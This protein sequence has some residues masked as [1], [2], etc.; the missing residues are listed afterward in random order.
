MENPL[1]TVPAKENPTE[2]FPGIETPT[3]S[4]TPL[5]TLYGAPVESI[6]QNEEQIFSFEAEI[7]PEYSR[8]SRDLEFGYRNVAKEVKS[9][10]S[11][12]ELLE[13][14]LGIVSASSE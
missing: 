2:Q 3:L 14:L 4:I 12:Q 9:T 6:R 10:V 8:R 13:R 5:E 1:E 11:P 7:P